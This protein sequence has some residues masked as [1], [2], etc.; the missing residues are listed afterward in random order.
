MTEITINNDVLINLLRI[1]HR[2]FTRTLKILEANAIQYREAQRSGCQAFK[3][4]Q[5]HIDSEQMLSLTVSLDRQRI[6]YRIDY[7]GKWFYLILTGCTVN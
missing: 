5:R 3:I 7:A 2:D 6:P 4:K 1:K